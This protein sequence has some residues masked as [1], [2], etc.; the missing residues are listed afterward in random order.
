MAAP[1]S[2]ASG[3][4]ASG[5][6]TEILD[7]SDGERQM[8]SR[9]LFQK[10]MTVSEV[11]ADFLTCAGG[12]F[13][14]GLL[15]PSLHMSRQAQ[16]SVSILAGLMIVLLLQRDGAYRGGGSLLQIRMTERALRIPAQA[17][18]LLLLCS[19]LL[20]LNVPHSAF[21][22]AFILLPLLLIFEK[23]VLFAIMRILYA[24]EYGVDR[25]VV[26]GA[27]D[28]ARR[29]VSSLLYSPRLGL[30]PVALIDDDLTR[31][32]ERLFEMGYRRSL[33]VTLQSGPLTAARLKS[34]RCKL[35]VVAVSNLSQEKLNAATQAAKQAGL[36]TA[37]LVDPA[38]EERPGTE[39]IDI[40]GLPLASTIDPIAPLHYAVAKR[41][42][43][44]IVSSLLLLLLAPLSF[45]IAVLIWLD[46]P[47][48]IFFV[49]KR[50]GCNGEFF[51]MYK[52]RSMHTTVPRYDFSPTQSC[53]IRITPIGRFLRR[54]S[55][56]ELPQL[57]NVFRGEM[58]LVGPRPEMPFIV[59]RYNS[60]QRQRLQVIPGITGLWQLSADRAFPIHENIQ[61]DLN[62]IQN[63]TFFMDIAILVHTPL[64]ALRGGI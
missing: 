41:T 15:C 6:C 54:T 1:R 38:L 16:Y 4:F 32:G 46:S 11:L 25:V 36:E 22:M 58:S 21:F 7:A 9:A 60:R 34:C 2:F 17:L 10:V 51:D 35:L 30:R 48:P 44:L 50:V 5:V 3:S 52:F 20:P 59:H 19:F 61:H 13:A 42:S 33:S 14:V 18:L 29:M 37:L 28:A 24:R 31:S 8:I 62:Y 45:L 53:D 23:Q 43:D 55:L 64:R 47:G 26:Y 63:R 56:D 57:I 39:S 40:G 12:V 49:Q 27:G